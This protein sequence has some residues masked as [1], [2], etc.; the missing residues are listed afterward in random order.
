M[1]ELCGGDKGEDNGNGSLMRI[2]PIAYEL[3]SKYGINLTENETPI[4]WI[5]KISG[6]THRHPIA[7][8][9][10]GIY[11]NI[12]VRLFGWFSFGTGDP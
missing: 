9:A 4:E 8:S 2:L 1:P 12:A 7:L 10:C 11:I 6:L 3:Y 5:H